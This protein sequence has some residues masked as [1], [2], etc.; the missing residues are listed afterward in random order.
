ME[1]AGGMGTNGLDNILD[2]QPSTI[3]DRTQVFLGAKEDIQELHKCLKKPLWDNLNYLLLFCVI[4]TVQSSIQDN[5]HLF[6]D[7]HDMIGH[8]EFESI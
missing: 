7:F 6:N 8:F 1:L 2:I 4:F 3:H 5:L